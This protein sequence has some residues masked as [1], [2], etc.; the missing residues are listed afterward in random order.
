[1]CW[2]NYQ[3]FRLW[4]LAASLDHDSTVA[5]WFLPSPPLPT[6]M[7]PAASTFYLISH[8]THAR[9]TQWMQLQEPHGI[10]CWLP[11]LDPPLP[12]CGWASCIPHWSQ[13][14]ARTPIS[15]CLPGDPSFG[16]VCKGEVCWKFLEK[17]KSFSLALHS[18]T[19][20]NCDYVQI[21]CLEPR[22][23][24]LWQWRQRWRNCRKVSL[25]LSGLLLHD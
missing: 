11:S 14:A 5:V 25:L 7:N 16:L 12:C 19:F 17:T 8:K 15:I 23:P 10:H 4:Q 21:W 22:R 24:F 1:M 3:P 9:H 6:H 13:K 2:C 18:Q 20:K